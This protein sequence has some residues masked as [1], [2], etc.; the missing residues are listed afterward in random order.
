MAID[1]AAVDLGG[2]RGRVGLVEDDLGDT[3]ALAVLVV[4][5]NN[6]LDRTCKLAEVFLERRKTISISV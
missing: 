1:E 4:G 2:L 3:T 5:D 6:L